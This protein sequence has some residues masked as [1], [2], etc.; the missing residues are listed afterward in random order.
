MSLQLLSDLPAV[1]VLLL[2]TYLPN[3]AKQDVVRVKH[4]D[5]PVDNLC[6]PRAGNLGGL[7]RTKITRQR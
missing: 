5:A 1:A 4:A 7:P 2:S 6:K 3:Y